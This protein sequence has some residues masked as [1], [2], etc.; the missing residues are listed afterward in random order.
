MTNEEANFIMHS[1]KKGMRW[2]VRSATRSA[3]IK[4]ARKDSG[5]NGLGIK[6][7][8]RKDPNSQA[9]KKARA[10]GNIALEKKLTVKQ[11]SDRAV[12]TLL[13]GKEKA[14]AVLLAVGIVAVQTI[15]PKVA[16]KAI[17]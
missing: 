7:L 16:A 11:Q 8:L 15:G 17:K 9:I 14:A 10:S 5:N 1:G 4:T 2:G 6:G 3:A 12:S 13:T